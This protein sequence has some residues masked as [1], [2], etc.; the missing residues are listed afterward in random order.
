M[1]CSNLSPMV[2]VNGLFQVVWAIGLYLL[3]SFSSSAIES[4]RATLKP[5]VEFDQSSDLRPT[6]NTDP[7][8]RTSNNLRHDFVQNSRVE[9]KPNSRSINL[10]SKSDVVREVK[11]RYN[12]Q[13]LKIKLNQNGS[14]Y[15]VRILLPSGR[16]KE[17]SVSASN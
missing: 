13:V 15:R 4:S 10:R 7:Y 9:A 5:F 2:S 12:A 3:I 11:Q 8:Q 17:V 1:R 16:V 6:L 14:A